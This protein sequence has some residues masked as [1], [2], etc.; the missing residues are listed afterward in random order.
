MK[1]LG[2]ARKK[3]NTIRKEKEETEEETTKIE[4]D[5]K[6]ETGKRL[7]TRLGRDERRK[8]EEPGRN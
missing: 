2:R 5:T 3:I 8:K 4:E 1:R 6:D 7:K